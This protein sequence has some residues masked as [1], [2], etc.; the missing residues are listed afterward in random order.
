MTDEQLSDAHTAR[1][2]RHCQRL[3]AEI[4]RIRKA[5][6]PV[7]AETFRRVESK[8]LADE[9]MEMCKEYWKQRSPDPATRRAQLIDVLFLVGSFDRLDVMQLVLNQEPPEVF[10]P[11]FLQM[12]SVCDHP[13]IYQRWLKDVLAAA[14]KAE[15]SYGYAD[16]DDKAFYDALPDRVPVYRGTS[17]Q[18]LR[19]ISWT[20]DIAVAAG[21]ACGKRGPAVNP[22]VARAEVD[23]AEVLAVMT[24]RKESEVI[25]NPHRLRITLLKPTVVEIELAALATAGSETAINAL[26]NWREIWGIPHA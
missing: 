10:W 3:N 15:P 14:H 1:L 19:G 21:F 24:D 25:I 12:W 6:K 5:G 9:R 8:L 23:K 2:E 26:P 22:A 18:R 17:R 20:T 4:A 7:T 13:W 16:P 11:V